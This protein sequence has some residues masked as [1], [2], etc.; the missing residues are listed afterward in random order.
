MNN[1]IKGPSSKEA[2]YC[3]K[4]HDDDKIVRSILTK[5]L[6]NEKTIY[7][8]DIDHDEFF[9]ELDVDLIL[10]NYLFKYASVECKADGFPVLKDGKKYIFLELVSNSKKFES[11]G[12]QDGLGC[13]L[14]S[15]AHFFIF[16]FIKYDYYLIINSIKLREF[17]KNN[18][19]KYKRK[20]ANTWS[21]DNSRI[22]YSS[23]GIIVPVMDIV[24]ECGGIL[25]KS[26]YKY[27]DIKSELEL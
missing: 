17:I 6:I 16:Y 25:K 2:N 3:K 24:K 5:E 27:E 4:G 26:R 11:S 10:T 9:R 20:T 23:Y 15:K 12:G 7:V 19:T 13:I 21:P 22:W 14:S 1:I 8:Y 18:E